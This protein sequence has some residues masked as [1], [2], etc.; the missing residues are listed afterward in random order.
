MSSL[1]FRSAVTAA[2]FV[3]IGSVSMA[4]RW[5]NPTTIGY[6]SAFAGGVT[7]MAGGGFGGGTAGANYLFGM[8]QVIRAQGEYNELT[9]RAYINY[10]E[11]R[12]KYIAN[13]RQWTDA[14]FAMREQNR[15][16]RAEK[17]ARA[18]HSPEAIEAASHTAPEPLSAESYDP[19]SGTLLWPDILQTDEYAGP[20]GRIDQLLQVHSQTSGVGT[21]SL[22]LSE[23]AQEMIEILK[24]NIHDLPTH[25]YIDARRFLDRLLYTVRA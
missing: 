24:S 6:T 2:A 22:A 12:S 5:F 15:V 8:S 10:E 25:A 21:D 11:A 18:R 19:V 7:A 1:I 9:T 3:S 23:S 4:Q 20:R 13:R 16:Y 17:L 14:Y